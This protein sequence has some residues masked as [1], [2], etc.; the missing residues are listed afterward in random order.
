MTGGILALFLLVLGSIGIDLHAADLK[1]QAFVDRSQLTVGE[2]FTLSVEFSGADAEEALD[3]QPPD[4]S[5]N[6]RFAGSGSSRSMEFVN[7]RMSSRRTVNYYY[8]AAQEGSFQIPSIRVTVD[9]SPFQTEP[10]TVTVGASQGNPAQRSR[11]S[12]GMAQSQP[13]SITSQDL[14]VQAS[15]NKKKI[16]QNEAVVL[17]YKIYTTVNVTRYG[18]A[19]APDRSGFW[20]EDLRDSQQQVE[21][22]YEVLNGKRY[23]VATIKQQALFPSSPGTKTIAPLE[24]ECE[25]RLMPTRRSIFDDFFSDPFGRTGRYLIKSDPVEIEVIPLPTAG[26]PGDFAGAVG[27]FRLTGKLDKTQVSTN[28]VVTLSLR[29]EGTGNVRTLPNPAVTFP[30]GLEAY[31]PEVTEKIESRGNRIEGSRTYDFV[32]VPRAPGTHKIAPIRFSYFDPELEQY[33]TTVV[34]GLSLQAEQGSS[35]VPIDTV[36][37]SKQDIRLLAQEIRFIKL[38]PG[39]LRPIDLSLYQTTWFWLIA[40][41]PLGAIAASLL[42][43]RRLDRLAGDQ[44]YARGKRA[45]RLA[46]TRLAKA[47]ALLEPASQKAFYAECGRALRGFAADRLNIPEAGMMSEDLSRLLADAGVTEKTAEEYVGCLKLSDLKHFAPVES[48]AQEM[49]E[50]MDRAEQAITR[51]HKELN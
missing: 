37:G 13:E 44:A 16:Y 40:T 10:I 29:L 23:T 15:V 35:P 28:D 18:E 38:D 26:K 5:P 50:F 14:F 17:T 34:D 24:L 36:A 32:L 45:G 47:Q 51:L 12:P 39:D 2:Q 22:S 49:K 48:S 8:F 21:T 31:D 9:G 46:R 6:A 1:M 43:R 27:T 33:Q 3:P 11:P 4:L 20:I 7:G 19:K 30:P 25:V 41:L 42:V